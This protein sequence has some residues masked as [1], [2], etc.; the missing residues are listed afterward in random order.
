MTILST[1]PTL[2]I[3]GLAVLVLS[4]P[5]AF[6]FLD[7]PAVAHRYR[8]D[9]IDGLRGI[10]A[11]SVFF[12][13]ITMLGF[14][15]THHTSG[16]TPSRFYSFL[17]SGA[18]SM[19]F[20][21]TGYLFWGKLLEQRDTRWLDL[22]VNR[23]FRIYPLYVVLILA[24]FSVVFI[25][26]G[27]PADVSVSALTGAAEWLALG[28]VSY[29]APFLNHGE[30]LG[31]VGATWS[32]HYE[33]MFYFSL[34]FLAIFA[35]EKSAVAMTGSALLLLLFGGSIVSEPY[36]FFMENFLVGMFAASLLKSFPKLRGDSPVRSIAALAAVLAAITLFAQ[37]YSHAMSLLLG[38]AFFLVAAGS[39]IFGLLTTPGARRLGNISYSIYLLHGFVIICAGQFSRYLTNLTFSP[40]R[41]WI[42]TLLT[43]GV[44]VLI[45]MVTYYVIE[46]AGVK[47]GRRI[48]EQLTH[49]WGRHEYAP[50]K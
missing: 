6:S 41:F 20:M 34:P 49:R 32:L 9:S 48:G 47:L 38:I 8:T 46:R 44:V 35:R 11:S 42:V 1:W 45:S 7:S 23:V 4:A 50:A 21:V 24:Y 26:A 22:Y 31:M 28:A 37:P 2:A 15:I 16:L 3:I 10:L 36:N 5:R 29:P 19:F 14:D 33:W 30:F 43:Y 25:R 13:H 40:R 27:R 12:H 17:G 18:V 39:S